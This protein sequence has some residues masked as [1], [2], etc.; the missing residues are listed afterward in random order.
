MNERKEGVMSYHAKH[1]NRKRTS[2]DQRHSP[3]VCSPTRLTGAWMRM[4]AA[5][6]AAAAAAVEVMMKKRDLGVDLAAEVMEVVETEVHDEKLA[7]GTS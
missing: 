5:A 7:A 4:A 6:A 2:I 1:R 3:I